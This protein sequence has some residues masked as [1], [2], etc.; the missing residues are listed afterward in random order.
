MKPV[1][2]E[3]LRMQKNILGLLE[4][5]NP[6][7]CLVYHLLSSVQELEKRSN[8]RKIFST[9]DNLM[10]FESVKYIEQS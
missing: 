8:K 3:V 1:E 10:I 7:I 4:K 6:K 9:N 5:L 2:T